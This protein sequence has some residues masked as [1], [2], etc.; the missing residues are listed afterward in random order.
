MSSPQRTTGIAVVTAFALAVSALAP[1]RPLAATAARRGT[2]AVVNLTPRAAGS[3]V[4]EGV[5]AE[6]AAHAGGW[7]REQS[8]AALLAGRA[9]GPAPGQTGQELA[10]LVERLRAGAQEGAAGRRNSSGKD[11]A[12]LGRLLGVD[13][14]LLVRVR[15]RSLTARLYSVSRAQYSPHSLEAG[16]HEPA[17]LRSYLRQ[18]LH[19]AGAQPRRRPSKPAWSRWWVWALA[20]GLGG[21][22]IGLALSTRAGDSGDLR[23]RISR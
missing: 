11:L 20:V 19:G 23:I 8:V 17:R 7:A 9:P 3:D 14:L 22:T 10:A 5:R 6:L 1:A 15:G 13:Y 18:E 4:V 16:A 12:D 2:L 21:L